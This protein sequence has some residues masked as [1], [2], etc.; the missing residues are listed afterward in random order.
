LNNITLQSFAGA[1]FSTTDR[2]DP[3][4]TFRKYVITI[5]LFFFVAAPLFQQAHAQYIDP[6]TGSFLFQII[7]S[8]FLF[9]VFFFT[10]FK[11]AIRKLLRKNTEIVEESR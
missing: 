5:L 11:R 10:R 6:G 2:T 1:H 4:T 7:V 3:M 8:G 9:L